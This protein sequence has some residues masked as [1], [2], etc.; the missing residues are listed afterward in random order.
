MSFDDP[1]EPEIEEPGI[2]D[3]LAP[4]VTEVSRIAVVLAIGFA[5]FLLVVRPM[6]R[7]A[8]IVAQPSVQVANGVVMPSGAPLV[9]GAGG[10][11][12]R[13]VAELESEIEAQLDA[14]LSSDQ[15]PDTLRVPVL[16]RR[17]A[18]MSQKEPENV[19]RLLRLWMREKER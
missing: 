17:V 19:A 6:M 14:Q 3:K 9:A 15:T 7:R 4:Q 1:P 8:G 12:P 16:T 2:V 5:A 18:A 13:T 11:M 10:V